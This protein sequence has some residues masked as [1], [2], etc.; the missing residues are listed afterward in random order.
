MKQFVFIVLLALLTFSCKKNEVDMAITPYELKIPS[1]FPAMP[2]PEDNPMSVEGVE[3]G[4]RLFY[5]TRL[6][7]DNSISCASCHNQANGFS[8]PQTFSTG[9][10][11]EIGK[12]QSMALVNLGW[13]SAYFWDGRVETLEEQ[14]L[15]PV[16]DPLEMNQSWDATAQKL[17][18]VEEYQN[19]FYRVFEVVDFDSTHIAKAISQFLRTLISSQSKYDVMY[20]YQN[21]LSLNAF[22]QNLYSQITN[23][24]WAGMDLF[25][26][27]T[28]GD[29]L[30]CHNGPLMEIQGLFSNNG[31]D[32]T[33]PDIGRM[34]V[35]GN[36][37]DL[38]KF[39]VPS[40]R[41]IEFTAPYMHDGRF[42]NLDEVINHYSFGIVES[43]TIDPLIEF[44]HQ[45]GVQLDAQEHGLIKSFLKT[46]TDENFLNNPDFKD[47][48]AY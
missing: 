2:I 5:D 24:E 27:L 48:G 38:G 33:F 35:T 30:H 14:V 28:N 3:L 13:Q 19:E 47:P 23:E 34:A 18:S 36:S 26:S 45:G 41:N 20:K 22:E 9:V 25:F 39:K 44:A 37:S 40:L 7:L 43:P 15:H 46:F 29:C 12:R 42:S 1:H 32:N 8:D 16:S 17:N 4:R 10:N 31:L 21:G 6:S 11:G